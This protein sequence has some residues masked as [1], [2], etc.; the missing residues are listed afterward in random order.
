M[1]GG[2]RARTPSGEPVPLQDAGRASASVIVKSEP[3]AGAGGRSAR[4][5]KVQ[6]ALLASS[7]DVEDS[8]AEDDLGDAETDAVSSSISSVGPTAPGYPLSAAALPP[9]PAMPL[10]VQDGQALDDSAR[11]CTCCFCGITS[12]KA[13]WWV[14]L[15]VRAGPNGATL[16]RADGDLCF[17]H[18]ASCHTY[19]KLSVQQ[20]LSKTQ[21]DP[22]F[23]DEFQAVSVRCT[24]VA[25]RMFEQ[26]EITSADN[27]H[28]EVYIDVAAIP[29]AA[30]TAKWQP[31]ASIKIDL[32]CIPVPP[33]RVMT[34]CVLIWPPHEVPRDVFHFMYRLGCGNEL[35]SK[36]L[37]LSPSDICRRS[38]AADIFGVNVDRHSAG[39][40]G[41][42]L[43]DGIGFGRTVV[44]MAD[45]TNNYET[46]QRRLRESS[47][48]GVLET[49][50]GGAAAMGSGR[51]IVDRIVGGV[52][53]MMETPTA[54]DGSLARGRRAAH[55]VTPAPVVAPSRRRP[56]SGD[57]GFPRRISPKKDAALEFA[58]GSDPV[59]M[60]VRAPPGP[61]NEQQ[62]GDEAEWTGILN[63]DGGD[64]GRE[65]N[66]AK[67]RL[68]N[69]SKETAEWYHAKLQIELLEACLLLKK[70]KARSLSLP[71]LK[72]NIEKLLT[73]EVIFPRV[74]L[75]IYTSMICVSEFENCLHLDICSK[76]AGIR[77]WAI[78]MMLGPGDDN[79]AEWSV[80][81]PHMSACQPLDEAAECADKF[82]ST[83]HKSVFN[84]GWLACWRAG[85]QGGEGVMNL[86]LVSKIYLEEYVQVEGTLP[87]FLEKVMRPCAKVM[88]GVLACRWALPLPY[89][90]SLDDVLYILPDKSR[91]ALTQDV[92]RVGKV[93]ASGVREDPLWV[94]A[95]RLF[96][97]YTGP[98]STHGPDCLKM[99]LELDVLAACPDD[100][101]FDELAPFLTEFA[102]ESPAW[103]TNLRPGCTE[104]HEDI[105][106]S[107]CQKLVGVEDGVPAENIKVVEAGLR[108]MKSTRAKHLHNV[109]LQKV[110]SALRNE[111]V[112]KFDTL[113]E[114][115]AGDPSLDKVLPLLA[116][117][118]AL[119][120]S[121]AVTPMQAKS[122]HA[123][124]RSVVRCVRQMQELP[125]RSDGGVAEGFDKIPALCAQSMTVEKMRRSRLLPT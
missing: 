116:S 108:C 11:P 87:D 7:F 94:E 98:E 78:R 35:R 73:N 106:V 3:R 48:V 1:R 15:T 97:E 88:R 120:Q 51:E 2:S 20:I 114:S 12:D 96:K 117:V 21:S 75:Q 77:T 111:A 16:A 47:N 74:C 90:A 43:R 24:A 85:L 26:I 45:I 80:D 64:L 79:G 82:T 86:I 57:P 83:Y 33:F 62:D 65:L 105:L 110:K 91:T 22:R 42:F 115:F 100:V 68:D 71:M 124:G 84:D 70:D 9:Q 31:A 54:G 13:K 10:G 36:K 61:G 44:S 46:E 109:I 95:K 41:K 4:Q 28:A 8:E 121:K 38:Q 14:L 37:M 52:A 103:V 5:S 125:F 92:E 113:T 32:S 29:A 107:L 40:D 17:Q 58:V 55:S 53:V 69:I 34:N 66:G 25:Q 19:P 104:P 63:N 119:T 112:S 56:L 60:E 123:V 72:P 76:Q 18:G 99:F 122:L 67:Q 81:D 102:H 118:L 30:F 50:G 59:Q 23:A 89:G 49:S 27:L 39:A 93:M 101:G 6:S